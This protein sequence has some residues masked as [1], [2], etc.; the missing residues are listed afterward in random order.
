MFADTAA[1]SGPEAEAGARGYLAASTSA[2]EYQARLAMLR[3]QIEMTTVQQREMAASMTESGG[4]TTAMSDFTGGIGSAIAGVSGFIEILAG[5]A[6]IQVAIGLFNDLANA[7]E[8]AAQQIFQLNVNTERNVFMWQYQYAQ[9][10]KPDPKLASQIA[11]YTAQFSFNAPFT[12]QDI[13][14]GIGAMAP[15]G[16]NLQGIQQYAPLIAD[17]A[18]THASIFG[19]GGQ[20]TFSQVAFAL[21]EAMTTGNA[22]RM[23]MELQIQPRQLEQF[24]LKFAGSGHVGGQILNPWDFL[25]DLQKLSNQKGWTGAANAAAHETFWGEWSSFID[26]MQN[27]GLQ[28]GGMNLDGTVRKGSPFGVI[29]SDLEGIS[30]WIDAHKNQLMQLGDIIGSTVGGAFE[31]AGNM[32]QDFMTG[33]SA[34]PLSDLIQGYLGPDQATLNV[35]TAKRG[36][37]AMTA[38]Q[39]KLAGQERGGGA[40]AGRS[41]LPEDPL[42]KLGQ[43]AGDAAQKLKELTDRYEQFYNTFIKPDLVD[44]INDLKAAWQDVMNSLTPEDIANLKE[45]GKDLAGLALEAFKFAAP[46]RILTGLL[47]DLAKA[48]DVWHQWRKFWD[49]VGKAVFDGLNN[50]KHQFDSWGRSLTNQG[51]VWG[52]NLAT[53]IVRGLTA[54]LPDIN[55][56]LG[57]IGLGGTGSTRGGRSGTTSAVTTRGTTSAAALTHAPGGLRVFGSYGA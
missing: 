32:I 12:R 21:M 24:G 31:H 4:I 41:E 45:L 10:G 5:L 57:S 26:R 20:L 30:A 1:A 27:L 3:D 2:E 36:P 33:L 6:A 56:V 46:L 43:L 23:M 16:L 14:T 49:D 25:P 11:A 55:A 51:I 22:R 9:G 39:K 47:H 40:N 52:A 29:K 7:V 50:L 17:L 28:I 44:R 48:I 42:Y 53:G 8:N 18:S 37:V 35:K 34:S 19:T 38:A 54:G 15:M 13:M